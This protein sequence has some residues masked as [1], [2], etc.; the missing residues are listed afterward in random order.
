MRS[1]YFS[2]EELILILQDLIFGV[3]CM[4]SEQNKVFNQAENCV[5]TRIYPFFYIYIYIYI[6]Y[7]IVKEWSALTQK[8][9]IL[10]VRHFFVGH[11][12]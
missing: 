12:H 1:F 8:T 7:S 11:V 10:S 9:K 4:K 5:F 3:Q 6:Y 2:Y